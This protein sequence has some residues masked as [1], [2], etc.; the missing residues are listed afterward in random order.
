MWYPARDSRAGDCHDLQLAAHQVGEERESGK[1][2][3]AHSRVDKRMQI[4]PLAPPNMRRLRFLSSILR[5]AQRGTE[6]L[7]GWPWR[8]LRQALFHVPTSWSL[9]SEN[10]MLAPGDAPQGSRELKLLAKQSRRAQVNPP[11]RQ[12]GTCMHDPMAWISLPHS[13]VLGYSSVI[14]DAPST[15]KPI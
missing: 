7:L 8:P 1:K 3:H 5:T 10:C 6:G 13:A 15:T 12:P 4:T 11:R 2:G 9:S 14:V